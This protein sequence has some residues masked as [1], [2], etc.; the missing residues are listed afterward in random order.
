MGTLLGIQD[1]SF[2]GSEGQESWLKERK[3]NYT[4]VFEVLADSVEESWGHILYETPGLPDLLQ[5][6]FHDGCR[7]KKRTPKEIGTVNYGGKPSILWEIE[8]QFD[9]QW[10]TR[11][12]EQQEEQYDPVEW[13]SELQITS[14]EI[15]TDLI[16]DPV[17]GDPIANPN[18]E[19]IQVETTQSF[20]VVE[21]SRYE[22]YPNTTAG[23]QAILTKIFKYQNR[24]NSAPFLGQP[25]GCVFMYAPTTRREKINGGE[26]FKVTYRFLIKQL[27]KPNA[28]KPHDNEPFMI[29]PLCEG[30]TIRE[31]DGQ[32]LRTISTAEKFGQNIRVN[33]NADGGLLAD[34]AE[35]VFLLFN[36]YKKADFNE[37]GLTM[38]GE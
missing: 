6:F 34:D 20:P 8:C 32:D 22:P 13:P 16:T 3:G 33:L 37:L 15:T 9:S 19:R 21:F 28:D 10:D 24:V 38:E 35:P 4:V 14:Q 1:G 25:E 29:R 36:T 18:G 2:S 31:A 7:C 11:E 12:Q 23:I 17:T 27:T 5:D 26:F 30:Y